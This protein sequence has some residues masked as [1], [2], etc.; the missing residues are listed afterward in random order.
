MLK[1]DFWEGPPDLFK[2]DK[3]SGRNLQGI[4]DG[5][6]TR[7]FLKTIREAGVV[8]PAGEENVLPLFIFSPGISEKNEDVMTQWNKCVP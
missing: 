4:R 5:R 7:D 8:R 3:K 1:D 2:Q 6:K